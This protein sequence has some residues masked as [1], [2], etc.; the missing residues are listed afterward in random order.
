VLRENGIAVSF[1]QENHSLSMN[2]FVVRGLHF[3]I[4]PA[5]Q[6]KLVRVAAGSIFDVVVDIRAGSPTYGRHVA[7][8]L[9]AEQGN[10]LFVPEGSR[11]GSARSSRIPRSS[12]K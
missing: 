12:T 2:R 8:I 7:V 9:S 4:P 3:Q 5:S 6:A 11:T 1:V 10:Q